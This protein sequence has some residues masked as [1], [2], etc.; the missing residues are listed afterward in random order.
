MLLVQT[1][2]VCWCDSYVFV[3]FHVHVRVHQSALYRQYFVDG[4]R[5]LIAIVRHGS[6]GH[7][8]PMI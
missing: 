3:F 5:R 2:A 1:P 8:R 4:E 6:M 7:P